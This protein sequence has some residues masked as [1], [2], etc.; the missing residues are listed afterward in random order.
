MNR[1]LSDNMF[2]NKKIILCCK[3]FYLNKENM[4]FMF[5]KIKLDRKIF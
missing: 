3:K 1:Y 5:E 2:I 4:R